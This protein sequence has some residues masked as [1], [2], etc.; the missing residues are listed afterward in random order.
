M[1]KESAY[2]VKNFSVDAIIACVLGGVSAVCM[3]GAVVISYFYNGYGPAAVGLLGIASFILSLM[4][5]TF[6][7]HA[8]KSVDGGLLMKRIAMILNAVLL[9]ITVFL[10]VWGWVR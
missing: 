5:I 2:K 4:G 9:L 1:M 8:W 3:L 7:V 6:S 10:Y